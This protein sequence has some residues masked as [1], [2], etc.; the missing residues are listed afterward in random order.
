M[1]EPKAMT[2][3]VIAGSK[4]Y[5]GTAIDAMHTRDAVH[6]V[7][8]VDESEDFKIGTP[9]ESATKLS[10]R[11]I[12]LRS[13]AS[14]LGIKGKED[15]SNKYPEGAIK[16]TM[17][18]KTESLNFEVTQVT[19]KISEIDSRIKD[20][21]DKKRLLDPLKSFDLPLD[22]YRD[23]QSLAVFVGTLKGSP[24]INDITD[25]YELETA[26]YGRGNVIALFVPRQFE[27]DVLK[28]LQDQN[29]SALPLP[30]ME[31]IPKDILADLD[32]RL[33]DL[34]SEKAKGKEDLKGLRDE[35][36]DYV[37][38]TNEYLS[39]ETQK[40]EAP[41]RFA[42]TKNAFVIEG[43]IPTEDL[44]NVQDDV[45]R[46]SDGHVVVAVDVSEAADVEKVPVALDNA[47]LSRPLE[48]LVKAFSIPKYNE[49]DPTAFMVFMYPF[50]FGLM[51]GDIGY[52]VIVLAIA[53]LISRRVKSGGMHDLAIIAL[54][55]GIFSIIFGFLFNEFF[56]VELF[57][58][59]GLTE[60]IYVYPTLPRLDNVLTLLIATF[61]IGLLMLSLGYVLGF[62]NAYR[63]H[64]LKHAVLSKM[65]WLCL[66]WGGVLVIALIL[67][68]LTT[69][70]AIQL[71][72]GLIA[73]LVVAVVGFVLLIMGEGVIGIAELPTLLS[74]V[75]SYSRLLSIGIS[76]TGIALSNNCPP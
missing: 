52:G 35:Y 60:F 51:L 21:N 31:G 19:D 2:K 64:G 59:R 66:L 53:V 1:L 62:I 17:D 57:G 7:D 27:G 49:I 8:F 72:T 15:I 50:L 36:I 74:N 12:S 73:G 26:P 41:L 65:S 45:D 9:Y 55:G 3:I 10:E 13:V 44:E 43:W 16:E 70:S 47:Y 39:I 24:A 68:P 33:A 40:A 4:E 75:L 18:D 42:T 56:G 69:G 58:H 63:Q 32:A 38:A 25:D 6:I 34:E 67:P 29:Y 5:M 76:S 54:Y 22:L 14:Y 71:S 61:V 11:A 37:L 46:A 28:R 48:V 20:I 23:Y 30:E